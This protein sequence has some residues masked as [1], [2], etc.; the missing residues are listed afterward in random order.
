MTTWYPYRWVC[1][2]CDAIH[3]YS[4]AEC[5]ACGKLEFRKEANNP[6]AIAAE[7][8]KEN[9]NQ[10]EELIKKILGE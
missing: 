5:Q 4:P 8:V 9:S 2:D 7:I 3:W 10:A 1:K 6:T